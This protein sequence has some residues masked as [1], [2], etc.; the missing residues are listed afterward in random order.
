MLTLNTVIFWL[1]IW[2]RRSIK[3]VLHLHCFRKNLLCILNLMQMYQQLT[4][5]MYTI[6]V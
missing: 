5:T 3:E 6:K 2:G 1:E 4:Q